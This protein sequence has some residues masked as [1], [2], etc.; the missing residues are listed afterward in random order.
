MHKIE[1]YSSLLSAFKGLCEGV[2]DPISLYAN[3]SAIIKEHFP[4]FSWVGFYLLKEGVLYL[5][6]FQGKVAC[7]EIK[8][9]HGVCGTASSTRK[10]IIVPNVH[11]FPGH[12]A[13]DALS[14]S[15]IV[16]PVIKDGVVLGVLDIDAYEEAVFDVVDGRYLE[17]MVQILLMH[18]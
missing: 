17:E 12:I 5:G 8:D 7:T 2:K 11:D 15:E 10:T 14:L 16:V 3:T 13:C 1:T 18:L 4:H 6:P 9:G